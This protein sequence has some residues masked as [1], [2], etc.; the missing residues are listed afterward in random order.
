MREFQNG[1]LLRT[2]IRWNDAEA[3]AHT[4]D[5]SVKTSVYLRKG[6]QIVP[7]AASTRQA[8]RWWHRLD[9]SG[10][11]QNGSLS[12][13][14]FWLK[15]SLLF[16]QF[17]K[18]SN[19]LD[20]PS[21]VY[22]IKPDQSLRSIAAETWLQTVNPVS[23]WKQQRWMWN[24]QREALT[25][26]GSFSFLWQ[27]QRHLS[28]AK[29]LLLSSVVNFLRALFY[30]LSSPWPPSLPSPPPSL[31]PSL[32]SLVSSGWRLTADRGR[33]AW[34]WTPRT[35]PGWETWGCCCRLRTGS[36]FGGRTGPCSWNPL[37]AFSSHLP[38]LPRSPPL[39]PPLP[40]ASLSRG[41]AEALAHLL[42]KEGARSVQTTQKEIERFKECVC[43]LTTHLLT[44]PSSRR[45]RRPWG[46]HN[47][48]ETQNTSVK[49]GKRHLIPCRSDVPVEI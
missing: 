42:S 35:L 2:W 20:T 32:H 48:P 7:P 36:V 40:R 22:F 45:A 12:N 39:L 41:E 26:D 13:G 21:T 6:K 38:R 4:S 46:C 37:G 16:N 9:L 23:E 43:S 10:K 19:V 25:S 24:I 28:V 1:S 17:L 18:V 49:Q 5:R 3:R 47:N 14:N 29:S 11:T 33:T 27:Q 8:R 34:G 31:P 15:V 44:S 30:L